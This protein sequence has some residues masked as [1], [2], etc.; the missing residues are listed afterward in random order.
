MKS[1][2]DPRFRY[3]PSCSTDLRKTFERVRLE[4]RSKEERQAAQF[5]L[6]RLSPQKRSGNS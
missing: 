1:I 4:Q 5:R 2:L 6:L 3:V